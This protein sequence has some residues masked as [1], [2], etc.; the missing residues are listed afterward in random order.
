MSMWEGLR[1]ENHQEI[2]SALRFLFKG[3]GGNKDI[4]FTLPFFKK[5]KLMNDFRTFS[6]F[7]WWLGGFQWLDYVLLNSILLEDVP[8]GSLCL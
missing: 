1:S 7:L 3:E 6:K 8:R 4:E 2:V 5:L